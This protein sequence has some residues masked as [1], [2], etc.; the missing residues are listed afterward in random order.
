MSG[1]PTEHDLSLAAFCKTGKPESPFTRAL[2]RT[3]LRLEG[4]LI[5]EMTVA[6]TEE[7]QRAYQQGLRDGMRRGIDYR[8][9]VEQGRV[10][11]ALGSPVVRVGQDPPRRLCDPT[12]RTGRT[13]TGKKC[14][15]RCASIVGLTR[16]T[17]STEAPRDIR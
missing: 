6:V 3:F 4:V 2:M 5:D 1:R 16:A 17:G 9:R 7:V 11:F 15:R 10:V 13:F 12:F 8:R 14:A